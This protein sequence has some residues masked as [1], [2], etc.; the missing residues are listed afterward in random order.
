MG[1][2]IVKQI[3]AASISTTVA[4][5]TGVGSFLTLFLIGT[6][7]KINPDLLHMEGTIENMVSS[8]P[9]LIT[10][11]GLT[12]FEYVGKCIP[13]IDQVIDS[14]M[15]FIAPALSIVATVSTFGVYGE[16]SASR[17]LIT[18]Q[19]IMVIIGMI[20]SLLMHLFKMLM[21][22]MGIGCCTVCI[23]VVEGT[24]TVVSVTLAIFVQWIAI[25]IAGLFLGLAIF[26]TK[27][28]YDERRRRSEHEE[29]LVE[30][31]TG[32]RNVTE[33]KREESIA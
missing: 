2:H 22:L 11:G 8:W 17:V 5:N 14:I 27:R 30:P 33:G 16:S 1:N 26:T 21:R 6:I 4:G 12:L 24:F 18:F 13:V 31:L 7:N 3:T 15:A 29:D 9:A 19:V 28:K 23:T 32:T 10:L 25:V 20:I